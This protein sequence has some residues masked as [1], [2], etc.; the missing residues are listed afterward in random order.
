MFC[1]SG[2]FISTSCLSLRGT[3]QSHSNIS[4]PKSFSRFPLGVSQGPGYPFLVLTLPS[5]G[6]GLSTSIPHA[7]LGF[8]RYLCFRDFNFIILFSFVLFSK[9]KSFVRSPFYSNATL[10]HLALILTLL[11]QHSYFQY[12]PK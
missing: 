10:F 9:G 8:I 5:S 12:L 3:K 6:C 11:I 4:N 1:S 7:T 2:T